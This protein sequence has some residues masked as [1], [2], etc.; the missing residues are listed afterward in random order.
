MVITLVGI[1]A[2]ICTTLA[3]I[4]QALLTIKT[5]NAN[6]ISLSMYSVFSF[7]VG[8]WLVYGIV[9]VDWPIILANLVTLG[10]ALSILTMKLRYG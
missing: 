7:G 10:L 3:F 8:M 2:A 9:Q 4:P 6:G 1:I 5:R